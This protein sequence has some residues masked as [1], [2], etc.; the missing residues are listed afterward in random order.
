MP[1]QPTFVICAPPAAVAQQKQAELPSP[2]PNRPEPN[3]P[4][5]APLKPITAEDLRQAVEGDRVPHHEKEA[6]IRNRA[7]SVA[8]LKLATMGAPALWRDSSG[9]VQSVQPPGMGAAGNA[10]NRGLGAVLKAP[11]HAASWAAG[12]G[13]AAINA[14]HN[15]NYA[16]KFNPAAR[17]WFGNSAVPNAKKLDARIDQLNQNRTDGGVHRGSTYTRGGRPFSV[18]VPFQQ[19]AAAVDTV[20]A[21]NRDPELKGIAPPSVGTMPNALRGVLGEYSVA[22]PG[23]RH[24][25]MNP[26][27]PTSVVQHEFG[28]QRDYATRPDVNQDFVP[29]VLGQMFPGSQPNAIMRM[30]TMAEDNAFGLNRLT[31]PDTR[32]PDIERLRSRD[33]NLLDYAREHDPNNVHGK[34][35]EQA[36]TPDGGQ[37]FIPPEHRALPGQTN[38]DQQYQSRQE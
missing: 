10:F 3:R 27:H 37:R 32:K 1:Y 29:Y 15:P 38:W 6:W 11:A 31:H 24:V 12:V 25:L 23:V 14:L 9:Q 8:A 4:A 7:K 13:R 19:H 18:H 2:E 20:D 5:Q 33:W 16:M 26:D 21:W 30:E 22:L 28:H 36:G 17:G 35:L 34:K